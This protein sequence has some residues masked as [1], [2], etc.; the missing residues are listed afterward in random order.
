MS[1]KAVQ[2]ETVGSFIL[3]IL[4]GTTIAIVVALIPNAILATFLKPFASN[5]LVADWLHIVTV[6]QFFTPIMA[7]FLI[8]MQFK[9]NAIQSATLGGTTYIASGAW[10]YV[11]AMAAGKE[12]GLFQ[13][14]GIGDVI[15][16]MLIAA[17]AVLVIKAVS[18]KLGSL[19]LVLL[20]IIV[21]FGVGWIGTLTL[22]YVSM[23]TTLIGKGIN[24]FTTLQPILM[25]ILISISFSII[26]ISPISTV[27]I[28][29]AIGLNGMSSAAAGMGVASAAALLV[30][31]TLK[32][33]KPGVPTAIALGGMKMMMPNFLT[34]PIM[35]LPVATTAAISSLTVPLLGMVGTPSSAGF[36]FVGL[37]SPLAALN[38]GSVNVWMMLVAWIVV[39]FAVGYIVDKVLGDMLHLYKKEI[40]VFKG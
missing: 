1:E 18:P 11:T 29:L 14:A 10:K 6:F 23:I 15:N 38:A 37:V 12:V 17:L 3:K 28:G 7:G 16:T 32:V 34:N 25:S 35:A 31:A 26:I 36:G 27:A 5:P 9:M 40:F 21:G 8:G 33:N 19:N 24:S 30:W 13:L 39:P 2:K 20:P 4:N 22:P